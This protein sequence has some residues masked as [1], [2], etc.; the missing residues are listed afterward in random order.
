MFFIL[1]SLFETRITVYETLFG[2]SDG[3]VGRTFWKRSNKE[4]SLQALEL[5]RLNGP[6]AR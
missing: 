2:W 3:A 1:S 4:N 6:L 5:L